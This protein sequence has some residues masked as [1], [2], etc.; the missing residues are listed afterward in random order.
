MSYFLSQ[1]VQ[2]Q[3]SDNKWYGATI[4]NVKAGDVY[5]VTWDDGG[6]LW[7]N[8]TAFKIRAP[9]SAFAVGDKVQAQWTDLK[10]Y[11]VQILAVRPGELDVKWDDGG[12]LY[13]NVPLS[14]IR[15]RAAAVLVAT[16]PTPPSTSTI[17]GAN[18]N[19]KMTVAQKAE[20]E[21]KE[22][23]AKADKEKKEQ[24]EQA[25]IIKQQAD[26]LAKED[27][28]RK[29]QQ[30]KEQK[31]RMDALVAKKKQ[32]EMEKFA[33]EAYEKS[34][35][36][37]KKKKEKEAAESKSAD[38]HNSTASYNSDIRSSSIGLYSYKG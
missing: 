26:K 17:T 12:A 14:K 22:A 38:G 33:K 8:V 7:P 29:A 21:A 10:W 3:Y 34:V 23:Q 31:A 18:N 36:E 27:A 1:K 25:Q 9:P 16:P 24:E 15:Q 5:D 32:E 20:K 30:E 28:E 4:V 6:S 2:V 37:K 19:N 11:N 35:A 13:P